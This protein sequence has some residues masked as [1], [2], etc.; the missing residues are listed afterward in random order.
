MFNPSE[1][2]FTLKR[3]ENLYGISEHQRR[4]ININDD[5]TNMFNKQNADPIKYVC[6]KFIY[7]S[8][9]YKSQP[10]F[11]FNICEMFGYFCFELCC[12]KRK[13]KI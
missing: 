9:I 10:K 12:C 13:K 11:T 3:I 4:V 7:E 2:F 5:L 6:Y 8:T 1:R